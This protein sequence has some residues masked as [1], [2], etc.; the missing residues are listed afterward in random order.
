VPGRA[1]LT[2]LLFFCLKG[3][4]KMRIFDTYGPKRI[5]IKLGPCKLKHYKIGD[6]APMKN[7]VYVGWNGCVV[8]L[9]G[10]VAATFP[11]VTSTWG[12]PISP[13]VILNT[14][15]DAKFDIS[16]G[17]KKWADRTFGRFVARS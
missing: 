17:L 6:K 2:R 11:D 13:E 4:F 5:Q 10:K 7:G 16:G 15:P 14:Q 12:K 8:V 1:A 9:K 3:R